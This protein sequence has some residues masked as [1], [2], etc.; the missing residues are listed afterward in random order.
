MVRK[1][2]GITQRGTACQV[3][4]Y[5]GKQYCHLHLPVTS[6]SQN[7]ADNIREGLA[8]HENDRAEFIGNFK[9]I[10]GKPGGLTVLLTDIHYPGG[11]IVSDHS[12][13][14]LTKGFSDLGH[15]EEGDQIQFGARIKRYEKS[16]N[17]VKSYDYKL[18][19]P[20]NVR[21]VT[22]PSIPPIISSVSSEPAHTTKTI[23]LRL[24]QR[25]PIIRSSSVSVPLV[26]VPTLVTVPV[27]TPV[28]IPAPP[29]YHPIFNS[30]ARRILLRR[31]PIIS[32]N[33]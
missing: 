23:S 31:P 33:P 10:G 5:R 16:K 9:R 12:W 14:N 22:I 1:C 8:D 19:H 3:K 15:L 29:L 20:S 28:S 7:P 27:P 2:Q 26:T 18:S 6:L 11:D 17:G 25:P 21:R 30:T 13:F 32:S 4:C 24:P